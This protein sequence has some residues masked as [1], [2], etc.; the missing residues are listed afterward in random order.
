MK[1]VFSTLNSIHRKDEGIEVA[2]YYKE[3]NVKNDRRKMG[4]GN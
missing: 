2:M 3:K 4:A 1:K